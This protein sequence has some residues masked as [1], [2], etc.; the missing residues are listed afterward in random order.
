MS[1]Y[2][3]VF[4]LNGRPI[5]PPVITEKRRIEMLLY[6]AKALEIEQRRLR[7]SD[8]AEPV[9]GD[10][11][12]RPSFS[13]R[14][15]ETESEYLKVSSINHSRTGA[16]RKIFEQITLDKLIPDSPPPLLQLEPRRE[17]SNS[18]SSNKSYIVDKPSPQLITQMRAKG[19]NILKS[20]SHSS[21]SPKKVLRKLSPKHDPKKLRSKSAIQKTSLLRK[22]TTRSPYAVAYKSPPKTT[23]NRENIEKSKKSYNASI[24]SLSERSVPMDPY[25]EKMKHLLAKQELEQRKMKLEFE[26]QQKELIKM[27]GQA[28]IQHRP[29]MYIS[30]PLHSEPD[31]EATHLNISSQFSN[32]DVDNVSVNESLGYE[33]F[34]TCGSK[35]LELSKQKITSSEMDECERA[36]TTITAHVKGYL[37]RRLLKTERVQTIIINHTIKD[38]LLFILDLHSETTRP[39]NPTGLQL[40]SMVLQQLIAGCESL[41]NIFFEISTPDRMTIIAKDRERI[42][43][44]LLAQRGQRKSS[45]GFRMQVDQQPTKN[46]QLQTCSLFSVNINAETSV[47]CVQTTTQLRSQAQN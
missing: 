23:K 8:N 13:G 26:R 21:P 34:F 11:P 6:K 35:T 38:R 41:Q 14:P 28:S 33:D 1:A 45:S 30:T 24:K 3:S 37:V 7:T 17:R 36:A 46:L 15:R 20:I 12:T 5:L 22:S 27:M 44:R 31:S 2:E 40:K 42:R 19:I 18:E 43:S 16:R 25:N 32:F 4:K 47:G 39:S 9:V 10:G 29:V